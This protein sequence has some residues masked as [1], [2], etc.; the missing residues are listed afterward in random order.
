MGEY[1]Y[2][3]NTDYTAVVTVVGQDKPGIIAQVAEVL[4][5]HHVNIRDIS[6]T[7]LQDVFNM[8]MLVDTTHA[9][10]DFRALGQEL[11]AKG[12]EIACR[13]ILQHRDVFVAMHRI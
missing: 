8:I 5:R 12:E 11:E 2:E 7:I 3:T 10:V 4:A 13:I 1:T 9:T 6:Q